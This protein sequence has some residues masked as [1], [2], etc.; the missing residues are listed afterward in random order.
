MMKRGEWPGAR[1]ET[2]GAPRCQGGKH[3][4][5]A[6]RAAQ[7]SRRRG[8]TKLRDLYV[9]DD[10]EV[11]RHCG[12]PVAGRFRTRE[13]RHAHAYQCDQAARHGDGRC[14][15]RSLEMMQ[16]RADCWATATTGAIR[17][18]SWMV[19]RASSPRLTSW[20]STSLTSAPRMRTHCRSS[21]RRSGLV[22]AASS[23]RSLIRAWDP[24]RLDWTWVELMKRLRYTRFVAQGGGCHTGDR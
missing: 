19:C 18:R 10:R 4:S 9:C 16:E 20:T 17:K 8:V 13:H 21:S 23:S 3:G 6:R 5:R 7:T 11:K 24:V 12:P 1:V 22:R 2:I 14:A 15:R